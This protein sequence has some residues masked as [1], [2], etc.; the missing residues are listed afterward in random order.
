VRTGANSLEHQIGGFKAYGFAFGLPI[1]L[2]R[3]PPFIPESLPVA[4]EWFDT[5]ETLRYAR[6]TQ[7]IM[8]QTKQSISLA[9]ALCLLVP[10]AG[11]ASGNY[12]ARPP[13]PA[14]SGD[15]R[16]DSAKYE[17]G[18]RIYTGK[19]ELTVVTTGAPNS[20]ARLRAL[21]SSLPEREQ[22]KT[23]LTKLSGKLNAGQ[24]DALEY[25]VSQRF[26]KK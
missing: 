3:F 22:K 7:P 1:S 25:Y 24:L 2:P 9:L 6:A 23:D 17:M 8:Q 16:I 13:R 20:E 4:P 11:I 19:T 10:T 26:P 21:Q 5:Q 12:S 18:K 14:V 15:A